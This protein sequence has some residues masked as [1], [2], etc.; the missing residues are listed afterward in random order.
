M[1]SLGAVLREKGH[2]IKIIDPM[3]HRTKFY[4]S[5]IEDILSQICHDFEIIAFSVNTFS[6]SYTRTYIE[7]LNQ[8][9]YKGHIVVGGVHATREYTEIFR[10][11][12]IDFVLLGEGEVSFPLLLDAIEHHSEY[13]SVP[14]LVYKNGNKLNITRLASLINL[15]DKTPLPAYDLVP[16][17]AYEYFTFETSRGCYADCSFCSIIYKKCWRGFSPD[18]V[19]SRLDKAIQLLNRN[20]INYKS[21]LFTDDCFTSDIERAKKILTLMYSNYHDFT[22]LIEVR[23]KHLFD[24]ELINIIQKFPKISIQVGVESGYDEGLSRIKKGITSSDIDK[25]AQIVYERNLM[26]NVF[27]SFIIGMYW[28]KKEDVLR[29]ARKVAMLRDKYNIICSCAWWIPFPSD[30]FD[31]LKVI[32]NRISSAIFNTKEWYKDSEFFF[33]THPNLSKNEILEISRMI[34]MYSPFY[35]EG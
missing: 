22:F 32:N 12:N 33:M 16:T 17:N 23:L 6:W 9:G 13:E 18:T 30:E 34:N 4:E 25:C 5:S 31:N 15:D 19:I 35:L 26:S 27:F 28:E 29:T 20:N 21:F 1:Y 7:S 3:L 8:I 10:N 11:T 14:N 2:T 24:E